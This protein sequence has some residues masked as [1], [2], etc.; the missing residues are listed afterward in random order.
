MRRRGE[1]SFAGD[2]QLWEVFNRKKQREAISRKQMGGEK[3][4]GN[5]RKAISV[6]RMGDEKKNWGRKRGKC[7]QNKT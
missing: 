1:E 3:N 5:K 2:E 4:V 6:K 7:V